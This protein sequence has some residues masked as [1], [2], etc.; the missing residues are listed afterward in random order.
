VL[1]AA[2]FPELLLLPGLRGQLRPALQQALPPQPERGRLS[3]LV[4]PVQ[5]K[6]PVPQRLEAHRL[7]QGSLQ[8]RLPQAPTSW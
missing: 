1:P 8:L 5:P 6:R 7:R 4:R 3:W 2:A